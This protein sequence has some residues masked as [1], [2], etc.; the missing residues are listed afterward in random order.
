[1]IEQRPVSGMRRI[2]FSR[3]SPASYPRQLVTGKRGYRGNAGSVRE[4]SQSE[5]V[6][7]RVFLTIRW[8]THESQRP[9]VVRGT[10]RSIAAEDGDF[11]WH[12]GNNSP[13][14]PCTRPILHFV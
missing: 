7:P 9:A 3:S 1:M 6:D 4:R 14:S 13:W 8:W 2:H 10:G 11:V 5:N 12:R